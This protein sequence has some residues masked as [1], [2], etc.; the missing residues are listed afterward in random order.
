MSPVTKMYYDAVDERIVIFRED[1]SVERL[2]AFQIR[3][4]ALWRDGKPQVA[5]VLGVR[6]MPIKV[7]GE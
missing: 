7:G 4:R 6:E 3:Q 5:E 1:G 2:T